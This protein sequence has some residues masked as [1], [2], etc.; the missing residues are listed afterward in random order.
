MLTDFQNLRDPTPVNKKFGLYHFWSNSVWCPATRQRKQ[1]L[2]PHSNRYHTQTSSGQTGNLTKPQE[3]KRDFRVI[4]HGWARRGTD[5]SLWILTEKRWH[6]KKRR[7]PNE[8]R[9][10]ALGLWQVLEFRFPF[11]LP[12]SLVTSLSDCLQITDISLICNV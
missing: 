3:I 7:W 11:M 9:Q 12:C 2:A 8:C 1:T 4:K 10:R 5:H 6:K